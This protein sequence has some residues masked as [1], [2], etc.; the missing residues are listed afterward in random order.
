MDKPVKKRFFKTSTGSLLYVLILLV[1]LTILHCDFWNWGNPNIYFG[2]MPQEFLY[3]TIFLIVFIPLANYSIQ[4]L[5]WPLP[6]A[7]A[8]IKDKVGE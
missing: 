8:E 6:K 2:W 5:S 7:K 3:R 4:K 1:I